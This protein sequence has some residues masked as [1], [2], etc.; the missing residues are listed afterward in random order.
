M[1]MIVGKPDATARS[2]AGTNSSGFLNRFAMSA[3]GA[4]NSGKIR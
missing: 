3:I 2:H 4:A 1:W